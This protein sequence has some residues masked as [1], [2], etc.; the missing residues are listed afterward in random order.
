M[1]NYLERGYK[2]NTL[3]TK[4]TEDIFYMGVNDRETE[5]FENMWPLP[6]GVAYNSYLIVDEKT[7]LMD[8]VKSISTDEF[9]EKLERVLQGRKLDY[10]FVHHMEPDHSGSI[11]AVLKAYPDVTLVGNKKTREMLSLFYGFGEDKFMEVKEGDIIDL[12]KRKMHFFMTP[13]V[14]WPESMVSY[15]MTEK[16]LFSQDA[17]GSFGAHDGAIFDDETNYEKCRDETE[18]YFVNIIGKYSKQTQKTLTKLASLEIKMILPVHG[19]VWRSNPEYILN[20]YNELANQTLRDGVVLVYGSM[21]GNTK[22][23]VEILAR[24][25]AEEGIKNIQ[26]F[27]V[28]K[29]HK[30]YITKEIWKTKGL[31]LA[32]CAYD[33]ALY[34]PMENLLYTIKGNKMTGHVLGVVGTFS[35]S[36]GGVKNLVTLA[37]D[38]NYEFLSE[39]VVEAKCA[40][41]E[42]HYE[43]L[44]ALA[45]AMAVKIKGE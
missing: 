24:A 42:E 37:E 11:G 16:V 26:V 30:S 13:M 36:G 6:K 19:L 34:P 17:F 32:S 25:L 35:W 38:K 4:V 40:P 1:K 3:V 31:I 39:N 14:H 44:K 12:G 43:Q 21:Y 5:L 7:A 23:M 22:H 9:M 8:T 20:L 2:M 18:R 41:K 28:S 27:D 15:D 45:K 29:T 33:N 10:L